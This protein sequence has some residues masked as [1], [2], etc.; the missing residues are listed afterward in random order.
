[1]DAARESQA[2]PSEGS[3]SEVPMV[4]DAKVGTL[5]VKEERP[6]EKKGGKRT[7][8]KVPQF[9]RKVIATNSKPRARRRQP[10]R[11]GGQ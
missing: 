6:S 11:S 9:A 1:M 8:R 2:K 4:V 5:A 7:M 10:W 3:K